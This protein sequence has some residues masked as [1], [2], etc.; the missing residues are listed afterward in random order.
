MLKG[1]YGEVESKCLKL[2]KALG[3]IYEAERMIK[4]SSVHV[5]GVSY[6]NIGEPG[7]R[8][9]EDFASKGVKVKVKATINPGGIDP[10]K[11]KMLGIPESFAEKQLR[12]YNAFK[13]ME[14]MESLT[15]TPYEAGN[16][17]RLGEHVAW[18][19]TS[20]QT[21][22]N[23]IL[24]A[25]TNRES[26]IS[27]LA[28]ALTGRTP[29]YG[30]HLDENRR[31]TLLVEVENMPKGSLWFGA[32]GYLIGET[33][34]K[35][36]PYFRGLKNGEPE[37]FKALGAALASSGASAI[38]HV[39]KV[40]PEAEKYKVNVEKSEKLRVSPRDLR[41]M[42][43]KISGGN[44]GDCVFLGCP[45]CSL[46]RIKQI[47]DMVKGR[48]VKGE[49]WV[50]T[51][52]PVYRE[53]LRRGYVEAVEKAGGKILKGMCIVVS[54]LKELGVNSVLTDSFKAAHYLP[55]TCRVDVKLLT[56]KACVKAALGEKYEEA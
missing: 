44:G 36:I 21:Y 42:T 28:S 33:Y 18:A 37:E 5:S 20:A 38:Y 25:K 14:F 3:E 8:L 51:S 39:E 11:W 49:F 27:A 16:K 19:E 54:P 22:A 55:E 26:G 30:L 29:Y 48:K 9:L 46:Q 15:C 6:K 2:L 53:A 45:H 56:F 13:R 1:E 34:G 41:K 40:S 23:S 10:E 52:K 12:I 24:G 4:V 47:A 7:L 17:P 32:L 50:F 31:P 35:A 43:D